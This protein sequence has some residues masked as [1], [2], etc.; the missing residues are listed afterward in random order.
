MNKGL[1]V[2]EAKWLFNMNVSDIEVII[3]PQSIIHS[4]VEFKDGSIKAQLGIPDMKIPIQYSITYPERVQSDFN[5]LDFSNYNNLT[6]EKPDYMKFPCL[7]L[8]FDALNFGG[9][10]PVV[11][12]AA[13]EV[14]VDLFLNEKIGFFDIP[15][16]IEE[17]L[18]KH[19]NIND[20]QVE[21]VTETDKKVRKEILSRFY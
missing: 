20:F 5:R 10:Y 6:F 18:N 16:I 12:N 15:G 14:A 3:H 21:D 9:T 7:K 8:A 17:S 4:M 13:N 1:E 19:N 11:L 2:I